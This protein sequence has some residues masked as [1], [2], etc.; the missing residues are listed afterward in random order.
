[1]TFSF[2]DFVLREQTSEVLETSEV[3]SLLLSHVRPGRINGASIHS[4]RLGLHNLAGFQSVGS[5]CGYAG[6]DSRAGGCIIRDRADAQCLGLVRRDA[7]F[8]RSGKP[9]VGFVSEDS[10]VQSDQAATLRRD[11]IRKGLAH[12]FRCLFGCDHPFAGG[13]LYLLDE[14]SVFCS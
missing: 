13:G 9:G 4:G 12:G 3:C 7:A 6:Q 11:R 10:G 5:G 14:V 8:G 1:M 2:Y